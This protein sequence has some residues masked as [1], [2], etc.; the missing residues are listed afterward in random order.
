MKTKKSKIKN[1]SK[2]QI[3]NK[4]SCVSSYIKTLEQLISFNDDKN[5]YCFRGQSVSNWEITTSLSRCNVTE[6]QTKEMYKE[7]CRNFPSEFSDFN[8]LS[9]EDLSK[10]QHYGI[11]THLLDVS[12]NPLV[13]LFFATEY[14]K[15][16]NGVK[17]G[18]VYVFK[19]PKKEETY[20]TTEPIFNTTSNLNELCF[21]KTNFSN[22]RLKNQNGAFIYNPKSENL[23]S[24]DW[25]LHSFI[26]Q[27]INK[28]KIRKE[29]AAFNIS[30]RTLFPELSEFR[31][32]IDER[33]LK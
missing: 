33:F 7:V 25:I 15:G 19:I 18:I 28:S 8:K 4:C 3:A 27:N 9:F 31:K 26:I 16:K 2:N 24:K 22:E 23:S 11:P 1:K 30:Y 21:L 20:K 5:I 17:S 10:M 6:D 29:L 12:Y 14:G 32:E 13:S